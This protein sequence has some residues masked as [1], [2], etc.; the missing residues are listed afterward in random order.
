MA[1]M[2]YQQFV[3]TEGTIKSPVNPKP[4]LLKLFKSFGAKKD[5]YTMKTSWAIFSFGQYF[6]T[7]LLYDAKQQHFVYCSSDLGMKK[8][9]SNDCANV[10]SLLDLFIKVLHISNYLTLKI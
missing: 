7:K 4:L 10:F 2:H 5:I 6:M 9:K 1:N 3:S 8:K